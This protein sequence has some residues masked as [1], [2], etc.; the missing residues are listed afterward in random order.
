LYSPGWPFESATSGIVTYVHWVRSE[1]Q[2]MGHRVSLITATQQRD[3]ADR[4]YGID[5]GVLRRLVRRLRLK[6]GI[7]R[8]LVFTVG[9]RIAQEAVRIHRR[10]PIDVLE[11]EESFG[12]AA[13]VISLNRFP[14]VV[15]LHGPAF[16]TIP[17][18]EAD[19][20]AE[21]VR[22]RIAAEG[23]GL[24]A[25]RVITAP[26]QCTLESTIAR[27]ALEPAIRTKVVNPLALDPGARLWS[28]PASRRDTI[29][30]VGRFDKAKGADRV[31]LGFKELLAHRPGMRLDFVG[32]DM[33]MRADDGA[34]VHFEDYVRSLFSASD[35][36]K[37]NYL[38]RQSQEAI[39]TLRCNAALTIVASRWETQGYTALEAMLQGCPLVCADTSGLSESVDHGVTGLLFQGDD[40]GEMV[41]HMLVLLDDAELAE[42]LG[43]RAREYVLATHAPSRVVAQTL[44]V[45]QAAIS[46]FRRHGSADSRH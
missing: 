34:L 30:F 44:A 1:L 36:S 42:N 4:I 45:Y 13:A 28:A 23:A 35:A 37:I 22:R 40:T 39:S 21:F 26:S 6:L 11:M 33:G 18:D 17:Q 24:A 2:R 5:S 15:K 41:R 7:D 46:D 19:A 14:L 38:G 16:L 25:A 20:Q 9:S 3:A 43:R 27:Y 12:W 29:L 10:D 31:L 32:P 8:D